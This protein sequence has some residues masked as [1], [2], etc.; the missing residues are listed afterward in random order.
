MREGAA[1]FARAFA[2]IEDV[3]VPPHFLGDAVA[4]RVEPAKH[5][6][7]RCGLLHQRLGRVERLGEDMPADG[8]RIRLGRL[9]GEVERMLDNAVYPR[10][11][12][13]EL[14]PGREVELLREPLPEELDGVPQRPFVDLGL[15]SV[16]AGDGV[17][18]MM[19]DGAIGLRLDQRRPVAGTGALDR[20]PGGRV[21]RHHVVAVDR[22]AGD[23]IGCGAG[24]D[25]GVE[26]RRAERGRGGVKVV[27]ADEHG[28]CPH[29]PGEVERLVEAGVIGGAVAEEGHDR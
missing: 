11:D 12:G 5:L 6:A 13:V 19:T 23:A 25:F 21:D 27:L 20:R 4:H 28:R 16:G 24:G 14:R 8:R 2:E 22:H 10:V 1:A 7:G 15:G 29:D 18:L 26:R 9:P 3:R 17:A